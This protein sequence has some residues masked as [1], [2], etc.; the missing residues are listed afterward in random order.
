M[1]RRAA[2]W[3]AGSG[4]SAGPASHPPTHGRLQELCKQL[5]AKIDAAEEEKYD[6]EIRVQKSS[7]E[8]RRGRRG[9]AGEAGRA[10]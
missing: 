5:H 9:H 10:A 6:M 2:G 3:Q 7:K 4:P 8:V 1:G